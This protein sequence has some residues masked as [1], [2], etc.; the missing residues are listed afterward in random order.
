MLIA[1]FLGGW[2]LSD[3]SSRSSLSHTGQPDPN[4]TSVILA[5]IPDIATVILPGVKKS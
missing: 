2:V 4:G 3:E 1:K 5:Q